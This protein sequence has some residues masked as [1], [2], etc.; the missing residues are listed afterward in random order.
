MQ[1]LLNRMALGNSGAAWLR[2]A[3]IALLIGVGVR[4]AFWRIVVAAERWSK[5]TSTQVDDLVVA[6]L[7]KT[8]LFFIL[9]VAVWG[10]SL[11]LTLPDQVSTA[12]WVVFR[13]SAILQ[14]AIWAN[15]AV[16]HAL[17]GYRTKVTAENPG[18]AT[19]MTALSVVARA[20]IWALFIL[21]LLQNLGVQ[22]TALITGLG[23][24]GIAIA[25]AVQ[26]VLGDLLA[27]LSIIFDRPFEVGD[28]VIVDDLMGTV[29]NVG[30]KTTRMQSITGEQ[31]VF[32]NSDLLS[33]RIR[34][35]KRMRERRILFSIGVTYG[36]SKSLVEEI[37]GLV[38][39]AIERAE[40]TRFDR[41]HFKE[42][43]DSALLFE[44]VYYMQVP[45]YAVFM[46]VQQAINL[47]L[48]EVFGAKGIEFAFPSQT[49]YLEGV[50]AA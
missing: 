50:E 12:I 9:A 20:V 23:I 42:F 35:Y 26:N 5:K 40:H 10:G 14:A 27:S 32:N 33:S 18:A 1:E 17:E 48:Y 38:Q 8:K 39:A 3:G 2:A 29:E 47:E 46:D 25:L 36:T 37:P 24:G 21:L 49:I 30:L 11:S 34:N 6:T 28:F 19:G 7:K 4:L 44:A 22:V 16:S 45:D 13:V 43:G 15:A 41:C 31:L